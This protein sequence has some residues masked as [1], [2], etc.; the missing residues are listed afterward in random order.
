MFVGLQ[1][2]GKTT[3]VSKLAYYYKRKGWNPCLVCADTFRAGAYEQLK[4]NATKIKIPFYGDPNESDP[5]KVANDGVKYF[6]EEGYDIIIVDTS[7]RHKQEQALF[8]E[9][10]QVAEIVSPDEIV[11]V[12]DG[13]IG[14]AAYDQALAFRQK[15]RVGSVIVTKLDGHAKG[16]GALSAV[17]ATNSPIVFLGTGEHMD[18]FEPFEPQSFVSKLLGMGDIKGMMKAFQEAIPMDKAPE[19]ANR[20]A[21]GKFTL[22]DMYEQLL[23]ILKMGPIN[24]VMEMMPGMNNFLP[25]LK[26]TDGNARIKIMINILDSMTDEELDNVK[27]IKENSR[28]TRIARGS[29]RSVREVQELLE[30]FKHFS[31]M[32]E[33]FKG[34]KG[35]RGQPNLSKM[36]NLVP[37]NVM[38]QIG[39]VGGLNNLMKQM[40]D[41]GGMF[42]KNPGN[43][44]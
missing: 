19:L 14:Q 36:A 7:G 13:S 30:Q 10:Q 38:K 37:P 2:A 22:R 1:G 11:F 43:F 18:D 15:V 32:V 26:G 4:M 44:K 41:M 40:G 25:Q 28:M 3:T 27:P 20:L 42:G 21:E 29:G 34:L 31:K 39:G 33:K 17:S 35:A 24:K 23:N 8:E 9:M 6:K 16:G 12:M 5:V